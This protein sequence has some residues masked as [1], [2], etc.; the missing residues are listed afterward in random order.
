MEAHHPERRSHHRRPGTATSPYSL[1]PHPDAGVTANGV[2]DGPPRQTDRNEGRPHDRP[3]CVHLVGRKPPNR[4]LSARRLL[5]V[6]TGEMGHAPHRPRPLHPGAVIRWNGGPTVSRRPGRSH[7]TDG[8]APGR[9][10]RHPKH[11]GHEGRS[12]PKCSGA[13]RHR[14]ACVCEVYREGMGGRGICSSSRPVVFPNS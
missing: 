1:T 9:A 12:I 14:L 4:E 11:H 2:R 7:R 8:L 3:T 5:Q 6:L 13:I 10:P